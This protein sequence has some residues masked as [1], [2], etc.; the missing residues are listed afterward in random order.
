MHRIQRHQRIAA[1]PE[2]HLRHARLARRRPRHQEH[3]FQQHGIQPGAGRV[4]AV[5]ADITG[6]LHAGADLGGQRG[7]IAAPGQGGLQFL[8]LRTRRRGRACGEDVAANLITDRRQRLRRGRPEFRQMHDHDIVLAQIDRIGR[9]AILQY[10]A[11]E[12]RLD[13]LW[14]RRDPGA[15]LAAEQRRGLDRQV[16]RLRR[17]I[18]RGR[19]LVDQVGELAGHAAEGVIAR[20]LLRLNQQLR[21][22]LGEDLG[23]A[24][25]D[26]AQ[27]DDVIALGAQYR[28][29]NLALVHREQRALESPVGIAL[30]DPAEVT[31]LTFRAEIIGVPLGQ[32]GEVGARRPGQGVDLLGLGQRRLLLCR[33]GIGRQRDQDVRGQTLLGQHET[34]L[35]PGVKRPQAGVVGNR[36]RRQGRR[37]DLD[38]VHR[39]LFR[40]HECGAVRDIVRLDLGRADAGIGRRRCRQQRIAEVTCLHRDADEFIEIDRRGDGA[41]A[42]RLRQELHGKIAA[43]A[44]LEGL[45]GHAHATERGLVSRRVEMTVD[46]EIGQRGDRLAQLRV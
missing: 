10:L 27:V 28:G 39:D 19:I 24:R 23:T 1:L 4:A 18:E 22:R 42:D 31:A 5:A 34:V 41:G 33:R 2:I 32:L 25:P 46:L 45:R 37:A 17:G 16:Q 9:V 3:L 43:Y 44:V 6:A 40:S 12:R 14:V 15:A 29:R 8:R 30:A 26:V 38:V 20:I 21:P 7:Q 36:R 35:L 11:G 13:H